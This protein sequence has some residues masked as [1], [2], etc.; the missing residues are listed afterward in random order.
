MEKEEGNGFALTHMPDM[1]MSLF[2][3]WPIEELH[4]RVATS[5]AS[6][7]I[8]VV[9]GLTAGGQL[10]VVCVVVVVTTS[11]T[12]RTVTR[13]QGIRSRR[14]R[15][16]A[17]GMSLTCLEAVKRGEAQRSGSSQACVTMSQ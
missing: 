4:R 14:L 11:S 5:Q 10:E 12:T 1:I 7:L 9:H 3:P 15:N 13:G 16:L 2:A 17:I 8:V 6:T